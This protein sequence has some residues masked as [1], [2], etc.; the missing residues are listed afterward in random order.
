MKNNLPQIKTLVFFMLSHNSI[1][2][3]KEFFMDLSQFYHLKMDSILRFQLEYDF[4]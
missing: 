2:R 1:L 4:H 3:L